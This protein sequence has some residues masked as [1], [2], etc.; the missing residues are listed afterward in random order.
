MQNTSALPI[1]RRS[2]QVD[3]STIAVC[4]L[5]LGGAKSFERLPCGW[6]IDSERRLGLEDPR[7][8]KASEA[9]NELAP[10]CDS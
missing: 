10:F 5:Y 4:K 1:E 6:E 9:V 2:F 3:G 7:R 8:P